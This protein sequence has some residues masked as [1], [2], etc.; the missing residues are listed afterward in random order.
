M[1]LEELRKALTQYEI[2][3]HPYDVG[4]FLRIADQPR[5]TQNTVKQRGWDTADQELTDET[6][7]SNLCISEILSPT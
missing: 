3:A 1:K 7:G 4:Y 6:K 2:A 5:P